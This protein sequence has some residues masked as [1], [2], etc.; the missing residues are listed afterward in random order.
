[1]AN[2]KYGKDII[3]EY[4]TP[5]FDRILESKTIPTS[6]KTGIVTP[7][8]KKDK[9]PCLVNSYREIALTGIMG[10]LLEYCLL[11]KK[12]N[13]Q[14]GLIYNLDLLKHSPRLCHV[15]SYIVQSQHCSL[16]HWMFNLHLM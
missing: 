2:L 5:I 16:P 12:G 13:L 4:I 8:I 14:T 6:F 10:K 9:E 15:S 11:N 3:S 1:M 7:V